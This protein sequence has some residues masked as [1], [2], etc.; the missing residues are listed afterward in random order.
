MQAQAGKSVETN[1]YGDVIIVCKLV[2]L[3]VRAGF[4]LPIK[5]MEA[6]KSTHLLRMAIGAKQKMTN[7]GIM[8]DLE[9]ELSM[10]NDPPAL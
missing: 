2:P 4:V 1:D 3:A 7:A 10:I 9:G 6:D 8:I 5:V